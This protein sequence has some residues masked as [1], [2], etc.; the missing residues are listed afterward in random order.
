LLPLSFAGRYSTIYLRRG[1]EDGIY[2]AGLFEAHLSIQV[3]TAHLAKTLEMPAGPPSVARPLS[4]RPASLRFPA[5]ELSSPRLTS[6]ITPHPAGSRAPP[7]LYHC[8]PL[9]A[10]ITARRVLDL[11]AP[12]SPVACPSVDSLASR[13]ASL[14]CTSR[15][16][17]Y[18]NTS[19]AASLCCTSRDARCSAQR[20]SVTALPTTYSVPS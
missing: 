15:S 2:L 5:G 14:C 11:R 1:R 7:L 4:S 10:A 19:R 18:R 12:H 13:A 9:L 20:V 17:M 8:C 6:A 3:Y 16:C